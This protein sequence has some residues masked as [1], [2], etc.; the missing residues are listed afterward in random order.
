MSTCC[1][2]AV[3]ESALAGRYV[4][5]GMTAQGLGD[6]LAT[7]VNARHQAMPGVEVLANTL[8]TLR[9]DGHGLRSV[10]P[11]ARGAASALALVALL[12]GVPPARW[13]RARCR[14]R[15]PRCRWS[16]AASCASLAPGLGGAR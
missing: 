15:W 4:L 3:P 10:P 14:W 6:T 5:I 8:Y 16:L 2:A 9:S 12:A 13:P 1:R 11:T 7:P